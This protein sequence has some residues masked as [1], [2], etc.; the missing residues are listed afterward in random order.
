[1]TTEPDQDPWCQEADG[2]Y[3]PPPGPDIVIIMDTS[4][5]YDRWNDTLTGPDG[6][7]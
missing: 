5:L 4:E 2:Q 7:S 3:E 1:M 6:E